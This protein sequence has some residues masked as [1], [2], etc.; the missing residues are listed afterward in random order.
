MAGLL[1]PARVDQS[2]RMPGGVLSRSLP[3]P[4]GWERGGLVI[5]FY[6]CGE[7]V[8][9]DKCVSAEDVPSRDSVGEFH[10]IPIEQGATCSTS[11]LDNLDSHALDR[12]TA[13]SDWALGRQLQT[14]AIASGSPKL[15][16]ANLIGVVPGSDFVEAVGCLEAAAAGE[17]FGA[18][19]VLHAPVRAAAYLAANNLLD[20]ATGLSPSGAPWII[21]A[22]YEGHPTTPATIIRLYATGTVWASIS[23]PEAVGQVAYA[24]NDQTS[25]ARGLGI[26]AFDPCLATSID[27]TVS[28]CGA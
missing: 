2:A 12:F 7:P 15:E 25:W 5:P 1:T 4:A 9:R 16:D 11:G 10:A 14:D 28:A 3:A 20:P 8:L 23:T 18:R 13:T 27:I 17:G 6:G 22:G 24:T 21:S 26:V 19:F